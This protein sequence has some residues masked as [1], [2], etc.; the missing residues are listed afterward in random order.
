MSG[1]SSRVIL[2]P[3]PSSDSEVCRQAQLLAASAGMIY[4]TEKPPRCEPWLTLS[5]T[6]LSLTLGEGGGVIRVCFTHGPTRYRIGTASRRQPLGRAVGAVKSGESL[7]I[8]D[9]TAGLGRDAAFL[10]AIGHRVVALERHPVIFALLQDGLARARASAD[11]PAWIDRIELHHCEAAAYLREN[12]GTERFDCIYLDPMYPQKEKSA[13]PQKEMQALK[14]IVGRDN[15]TEALLQQA[16][17]CSPRV[18]LKRPT[19]EPPLASGV[20]L[21]ICSKLVRFDVYCNPGSLP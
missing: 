8:L 7:V 15:D 1:S 10:A 21:E 14:Q 16:R 18:V 11:R 3:S 20:S 12:G 6:E 19:T 4:S 5:Q 13:K 17:A 9:A 2:L